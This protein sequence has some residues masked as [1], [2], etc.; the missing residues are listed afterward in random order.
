MFNLGDEV[1]V[2]REQDRKW[3]GPV[4]VM[5]TAGKEI[6]VTD[7]VK[8][9]MYGISQVIPFRADA[10]DRDLRRL[11]TGLQKYT[12]GYAPGVF[13]TEV[14]ELSD[15]RARTDRFLKAMKAETEGLRRDVFFDE[16][17]A[18]ELG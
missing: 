14:N 7:G 4:K 1:H 6:T 18:M 8:Y 2:Y 10:R 13:L 11:L 12:Q 9:A 17:D 15:P 3:S 16:I 5:R